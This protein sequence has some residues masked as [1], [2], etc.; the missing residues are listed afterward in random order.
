MTSRTSLLSILIPL[1][2]CGGAD[3]VSGRSIA[4]SAAAASP[5]DGGLVTA[6]LIAFNDFH[7][8]LEVPVTSPLT[9]GRTEAGVPVKVVAG[10]AAY[11]AAEVAAL[12][13]EEPNTLVVA[14]GD[15]VG[16]SPLISGGFHDE[17]TIE[18]MNLIGLDA[19]AVG[20]HEFDKGSAEL[21][22]L[23]RGGCAA[24]GCPAGTHFDG[25]RF[26]YLAANVATDASGKSTLFPSYVVKQLGG[27]P[28]ALIGLTLEGT[29]EIVSPLGVAGL[30]FR[31]EIETVNG[32]I[33]ELHARGIHAIVVL[34]H[35]GGN[36]TGRAAIDGC[37]ELTGEIVDIVRGLDR[38]VDIV[39]SG[40]SHAAYNCVV[41]GRRVTQ[42]LSY[43]RVIT[44]IKLTLDRATGDIRST[45]AHNLIVDPAQLAPD[46]RIVALVERYAALIAPVRDRVVGHADFALTTPPDIATSS[47][48]SM[49]GAIIADAMLAASADPKLGGAVAACTNPG[50]VR[51]AI[52][53]NPKKEITHGAAFSALPFGNTLVTL[54]LTGAQL[55]SLLEDQFR[56]NPVKILQCSSNFAFSWSRSAAVGQKVDPR[57]IK[58]GGTTIDPKKGYRIAVNNFIAAGGDGFVTLK[59]G[60]DPVGGIVDIEALEAY[61][62]RLD[63]VPTPAANRVTVLP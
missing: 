43:G 60:K 57:S 16:A 56:G 47:G 30:R 39:V 27:I 52:M 21:V 51:T 2:A 1:A 29:P 45:D 44:Q 4:T 8:N 59:E 58:I 61:L 25:A 46:P 33:P 34:I 6:Q 50:G 31:D 53:P 18:A 22:R 17:P 41:D 54:T 23:Q 32:L 37:N 14:A 24:E 49:L 11:F 3:A 38:D 36:Q 5:A 20:N 26:S 63:P 35:E 62:K 55:D 7:G 12:R 42:A 28:V 9:V 48:E 10:G 15:L 40:H 19:T 13:A